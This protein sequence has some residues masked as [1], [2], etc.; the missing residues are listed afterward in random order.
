VRFERSEEIC[1]EFLVAMMDAS[2][3]AISFD[4]FDTVVTRKLGDP[5]MVFYKAG[6]QL[7]DR[8]LIGGTAESFY[9]HRLTAETR[10][11]A[12]FAGR[13]VTLEE[14]YA[15]M[16]FSNGLE[17]Q[18]AELVAAEVRAENET[19]FSIPA[20]KGILAAARKRFGKVIF[21]SD[22]YLSHD[23]IED[24]LRTLGLKEDED[25][26]YVS[27][28]YGYWKGDGRLYKRVL[29]DKGLEPESLLHC[30][31]SHAVDIVAA[32]RIGLKTWYFND[33][34]PTGSEEILNNFGLQSEAAT[35]LMAGASRSVRLLGS[36]LKGD[37]KTVWDTGASVTGPLLL[38]YA[39]WIVDRAL[40][41]GLKRLYFLARD[42]RLPY[43]AV[44]EVLASSPEL[45]LEIHYVYGSRATYVPLEIHQFGISEWKQL[46]GSLRSPSADDLLHALVCK[47][48]VLEEHLAATGLELDDWQRPLE[49]REL[50]RI[51]DHATSS[52]PFNKALS[53]GFNDFRELT[54]E[55]LRKRGLDEPGGIGLV[56]T[57]WTT[58]S[59]YPLFE[60]IKSES[61]GP[62]RILY[63]GLHSP[64][65][66]VS[67]EHVDTFLFN[68]ASRNG[69]R[70][71]GYLYSRPIETLLMAPHGRT[72]GFVLSEDGPEP[73]L[74]PVDNPDFIGRLYP[75][76]KEAIHQFVKMGSASG[77]LIDPTHDYRGLAEK[78]IRRFW[79][80]P[81]P[82]EAEAWSSLRWEADV[83]G[84]EF[85]NL[86]KPYRFRDAWSAFIERA[87]P[88]LYDQFWVAGAREM[89]PRSRR[90]AIDAA[91]F[92]RR[93]LS[94]FV[95]QVP[96]PIKSRL[97]SLIGYFRK[98]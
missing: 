40:A 87:Y 12:N 45:N 38:L 27:S 15:E 4:V 78:I 65:P 47:R 68:R 79:E 32:G 41:Q 53:R 83:H 13:E 95:K 97:R 42:A 80:S 67:L 90:R 23:F 39:R 30:G 28:T 19:I 21:I 62:A 61:N 66:R 86:A 33:A 76:Y 71:A 92:A 24:R 9:R 3:K 35:S 14:I 29:Q 64:E 70:S 72:A 50:E 51:R 57:G 48:E 52:G 59:H 55:Y 54:L 20:A 43:L 5:P 96:S 34:N 73:V 22:M 88:S 49:V 7:I 89:T 31:N 2:I 1:E 25:E 17:D 81:T 10:A 58:N 6:K 91:I 63:M 75:Y 26:L 37:E 93:I 36:G 16:A 46:I 56:D 82:A 44:E 84:K 8:G 11:R 60:L 98:S 69:P 74:G 94:R 85:R 77:A 18:V